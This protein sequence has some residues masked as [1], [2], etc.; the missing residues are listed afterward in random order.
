MSATLRVGV[1]GCGQIVEH[2]V[3][4]MLPHIRSGRIIVHVLVDPRAARINAIRMLLSVD[5]E[6]RPIEMSSLPELLAATPPPVDAV[7]IAVPHD[8]HEE[9]ATLALRAGLHVL[10][11]KP[12]APTLA[13]CRQLQS[14]ASAS[15]SGLLVVSEQSPH[16]PE[17][18]ACRSLIET[19]AVGRVLSVSVDYYESMAAT[20]FGGSDGA[21]ED[22]FNLG[23]RRSLSCAGG[24]IVID[25]GLHWLRPLRLLLGEEFAEVV[26][27][28]ANPW[29]E[30]RM[31]GETLAH[32]I[33]HTAPSGLCGV[34]RA[35]VSG[36]GAMAHPSCPFMRVTGQS[37]E[38]VISGT[39]LQPGGGGLLL[40]A[41]GL[42]AEGVEQLAPAPHP[43]GFCAAF[44]GMWAEFLRVVETD[45]RAAACASVDEGIRDVAAALALYESARTRRWVR[46][47][48]GC[49]GAHSCK[50]HRLM[51]AAAGVGLAG[52]FAGLAVIVAARRGGS[53][54]TAVCTSSVLR[55]KL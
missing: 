25:G 38:I 7:L 11:E 19:G 4:A 50:A 14:V 30:L 2:H 43:R 15:G 55:V 5:Q 26:G 21:A 27:T 16:W 37:G 9:V 13:A 54:S 8:L 29:D 6:E 17:V 3:K 49:G 47:G 46:V 28:T 36:A 10:C 44:G 41:P 53:G 42:P 35:A 52:I 32:A 24:G 33:F 22:P 48:P 31:E 1:V 51:L 20:P 40:F 18:V 23:W 12:L 34:F 45:D 39:G